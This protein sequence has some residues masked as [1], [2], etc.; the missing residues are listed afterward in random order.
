MIFK[1][2]IIGLIQGLTEFLPVSSSGHILLFS[3]IFNVDC[4]ILLLSI[5]AHLGTLFAV[6]VCMRKKI[7]ALIKK[8]FSKQT[9][10]LVIASAPAVLFVLL[11]S[12][13][14]DKLYGIHFVMFG[15]IITG[16]LL[17]FAENAKVKYLSPNKKTSLF[18]GLMQGFAIL[19]GVSRS[20]STMAVGM[21]SGLSKK[22]ACEF[23]FLMSIPIIIGSA[24]WESLK[25]VGSNIS[26]PLLP[27][28]VAFITSFVFGILS[29]KIMLKVVNNKK[30]SYFS[31]YMIVVA[32]IT[33]FVIIIK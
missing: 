11:F 25:L 33:L 22:E 24:L 18:M 14:I 27:L 30:L 28:F 23:T 1:F 19:P 32:I 26:F 3:K 2:F 7:I 31:I 9:L 21:F 15:F 12:N 4:D 13:L 8:P 5:V 10:N 6:F 29:I 20:G 17:L 16:I